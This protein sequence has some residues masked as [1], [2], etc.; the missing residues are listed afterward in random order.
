[1]EFKQTEFKLIHFR[2]DAEIVKLV[3]DLDNTG[4]H[5]VTAEAPTFQP[6]I[7]KGKYGKL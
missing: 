4:A 3:R 1:M 6:A 7:K 5:I 2:H